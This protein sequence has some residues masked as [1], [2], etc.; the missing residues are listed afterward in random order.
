MSVKSQTL[1]P[2]SRQGGKSVL[3]SF[4]RRRSIRSMAKRELGI[5]DLSDL[6]WATAGVNGSRG[7]R[8]VPI[9][10]DMPL[11][12]AIEDGVFRYDPENHQLVPVLDEDIRNSI[13]TQGFARTAPV[14]LLLSQDDAKVNS[15]MRSMIEETD[16]IPFYSGL[17]IGYL[18]QSIYL[19]S[20]GL[21]LNTVALGY[22]DRELIRRKLSFGPGQDVCLVHPVE[23]P[24]TS[25]R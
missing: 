19:A 9:M 20:A 17:H 14:Q 25:S 3:E 6:L 5:Q 23:Y 12:A 11:Y 24:G 13:P 15:S 7:L 4:D 2:P 18:S 8:T 1:P 16:G 22:F 10:W 21:G